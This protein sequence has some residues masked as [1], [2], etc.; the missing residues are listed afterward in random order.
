MSQE[1]NPYLFEIEL[2]RK[3]LADAQR[4]REIC[5]RERDEEAARFYDELGEEQILRD[6]LQE[7]LRDAKIRIVKTNEENQHLEEELARAGDELEE[8]RKDNPKLEDELDDQRKLTTELNNINDN[9]VADLVQEQAKRKILA[10]ERDDFE[11]RLAEATLDLEEKGESEAKAHNDLA[12][13]KAQIE[14][15]AHGLDEQ[16]ES[17]QVDIDTLQQ[18]VQDHERVVA[19]K[20]ERIAYL[21]RE[22]EVLEDRLP[23]TG[24]NR[25]MN[26]YIARPPTQ[27][28]VSNVSRNSMADELR[29]PLNADFDD[30]ESVYARSIDDEPV[31]TSVNLELSD[32]CDM[33]NTAPHNAPVPD[34]SIYISDAASTTPQPQRHESFH[35]KYSA[36][37]TVYSIE[38][39]SPGEPVVPESSLCEDTVEDVHGALDYALVFPTISKSAPK[40]EPQKLS[41]HVDESLNYPPIQPSVTGHVHVNHPERHDSLFVPG[42]A[43]TFRN[44]RRPLDPLPKL[45]NRLGTNGL[46]DLLEVWPL[47]TE[48]QGPPPPIPHV[49]TVVAQNKGSNRFFHY[50]L[51]TIFVLLCLYCWRVKTQL[52]A[53]EHANGVGFGEG[54]GNVHDHYGSPYGNGHYLLGMLPHNIISADSLLPE[55]A[56]V[57]I[58]S[59]MSALENWVGLGPTPMF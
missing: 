33:I 45:D 36:V 32:V 16:N 58:T 21:E 15:V 18:K 24:A 12:L 5:Q 25:A 53:W 38:P 51:H 4:E 7:E 27:R 50:V 46:D 59:T 34:M 23:E 2:L 13:Y 9:L 8:L 40:A 30:Y 29:L 49:Q 39:V 55:K 31:E 42:P 14:Q 56:V 28:S 3:Q 43:K 1:S 54:Y 20:D 17:L 57:I 22:N 37:S 6:Q 19:I 44:R 52:H 47:G 10:R 41:L 35:V 26:D 11:I 48:A